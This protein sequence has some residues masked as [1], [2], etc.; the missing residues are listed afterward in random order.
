MYRPVAKATVAMPRQ[1]MARLARYESKCGTYGIQTSAN[2]PMQIAFS[3]EPMPG[4]TLSGI[5][6]TRT[7]TETTMLACP[8]VMPRVFEMPC[9]KTS[10]GGTPIWALITMARARP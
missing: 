7:M 8:Y 3:T 2:K 4:F 10:Q 9:A 6:A 1:N 5:Q